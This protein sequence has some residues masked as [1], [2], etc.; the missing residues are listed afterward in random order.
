[1]FNL[2]VNWNALG[3]RM[4]NSMEIRFSSS[5]L[6][7]GA[8]PLCARASRSQPQAPKNGP[9]TAAESALSVPGTLLHGVVAMLLLVKH[10]CG[11]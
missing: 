4:D 11:P 7:L 2:T 10:G 6:L 1:M 8:H 9:R 5:F 3:M